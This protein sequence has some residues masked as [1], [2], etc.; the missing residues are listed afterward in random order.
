LLPLVPP[1][2]ERVIAMPRL[3]D[4]DSRYAT[5]EEQALAAAANAAAGWPAWSEP[6][7]VAVAAE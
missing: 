1:V 5:P 4:W 3:R 2:F 7:G 6:R